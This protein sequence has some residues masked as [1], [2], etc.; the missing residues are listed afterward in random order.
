MRCD[1][2]ARSVSPNKHVMYRPHTHTHTHTLTLLELR[3][4]RAEELEG[5]GHARHARCGRSDLRGE[6]LEGV[7][8]CSL[9]EASDK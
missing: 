2:V 5:L 4:V 3:V 7:A 9:T 6:V 8:H 1:K